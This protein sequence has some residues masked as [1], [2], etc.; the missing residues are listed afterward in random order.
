MELICY[1]SSSRGN[2]YI[3]KGESQT[4]LLEAGLPL[5]NVRKYI[6]DFSQIKG[7]LISHRHCD[8]AKYMGD[9]MKA[10]IKCY[11]NSDVW[12]NYSGSILNKGELS[13]PIKATE[14]GEFIVVPMYANHDVPCYAYLISHPEMGRL[15]FLT[16]SAGFGCTFEKLDHIM[17]ECNWSEDCMAKAIEDGRTNS[18]VAKRSRDTHMSIDG[19]IDYVTSE[20]LA[21]SAK[22]VILLHLSHE[23]SNQ[24][25]FIERTHNSLNKPIYVAENGLKLNLSI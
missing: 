24:Q 22:E 8:H 23:N 9:F 18:Y 3:L 1:G 2:G 19:M 14:I 25:Q 17:I 21:D 20:N 10:G 13:E 6:S 11:A 7:C 12:D 15:L 16:D 5:S 4:L